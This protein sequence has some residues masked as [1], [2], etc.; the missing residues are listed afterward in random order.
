MNQSLSTHVL[1]G[2]FPE[3]LM[4]PRRARA[5]SVERPRPFLV[6]PTDEAMSDEPN[7]A[8]AR[9]V[10]SGAAVRLVL[11]GLAR[12]PVFLAGIVALAGVTGI[13]LFLGLMLGDL[14]G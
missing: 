10:A 14:I 13:G 3:T 7:G 11:G 6:E 1:P 2:T 5:L 12:R 9:D 8:P 4:S